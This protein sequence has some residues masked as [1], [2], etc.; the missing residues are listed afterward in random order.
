MDDDDEEAEVE[1]DDVA[2]TTLDGNNVFI[3]GKNNSIIDCRF[4]LVL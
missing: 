4:S 1:V 3:N 2:T